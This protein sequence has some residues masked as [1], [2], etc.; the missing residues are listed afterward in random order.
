[1]TEPPKR[2]Y[3]H[4]KYKTASHVKNWAEY[5]QSL[6]DRGDITLWISQEA[7]DAWT[8]PHTGQRGAPPVYSNTASTGLVGSFYTLQY[9][10]KD[11]IR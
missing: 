9:A 4:P 2:A 7:I 8:P 5:E 6:R 1:M 10:R 3:R 11:R